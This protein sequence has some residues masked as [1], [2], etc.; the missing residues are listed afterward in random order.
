MLTILINYKSYEAKVLSEPYIESTFQ[1]R[2]RYF[3]EARFAGRHRGNTQ[4]ESQFREQFVERFRR[5]HFLPCAC[6]LA[7][8]VGRLV[9]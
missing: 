7:K 8:S 2:F 1:F 9:P 5:Y 4:D 3:A 6:T